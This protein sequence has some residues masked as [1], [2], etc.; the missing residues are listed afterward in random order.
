MEG[1]C[2]VFLRGFGLGGILVED[3]VGAVGAVGGFGFA[4][5]I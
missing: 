3:V 1:F 4:V 5:W 2:D